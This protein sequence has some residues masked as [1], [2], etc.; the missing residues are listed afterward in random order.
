MPCAPGTEASATWKVDGK[1]GMT[2][3]LH[4]WRAGARSLVQS[5]L[6]AVSLDAAMSK[7]ATFTSVAIEVLGHISTLHP[8]R[9][10]SA[11]LAELWRSPW[12][13]SANIL[14][15]QGRDGL[16]RPCKLPAMP[17]PETSPG[18]SS[19]LFR[20][21]SPAVHRPARVHISQMRALHCDP[22]GS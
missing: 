3:L 14:P 7:P 12:G 16:L 15:E 20:G 22:V 1:Q 21:Q 6:I 5:C 17:V 18:G 9:I 10:P 2:S 11:F 8:G 4:R 19:V 13:S